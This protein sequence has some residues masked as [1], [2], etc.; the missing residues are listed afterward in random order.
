MDVKILY[1]NLISKIFSSLETREK[2]LATHLFLKSTYDYF[3]RKK[4]QLL[5]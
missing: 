3:Q 2:W 4:S 1:G 5:T